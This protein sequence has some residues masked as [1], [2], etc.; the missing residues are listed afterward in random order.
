MIKD[1]IGVKML[2]DDECV[3][4]G[5]ITQNNIP[6]LEQNY[7]EKMNSNN[8]FSEKRMFRK[9][10]SIPIVA[11]IKAFQDGYNL[12]DNKD[13]HRFLADNP[14]Y[15]TVEKIKHDNTHNIIVR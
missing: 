6:V 15:M 5:H 11:H 10:A 12:D 13:L 4:T 8:G 14:D 3:L 7:V 1:N 2:N 9:I